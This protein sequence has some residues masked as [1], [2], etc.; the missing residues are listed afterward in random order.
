MCLRLSIAD[1]YWKLVSGSGAS[2][3][4]WGDRGEAVFFSALD[5]PEGAL[6]DIKILQF[7]SDFSYVHRGPKVTDPKQP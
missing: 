6:C 7:L 1:C 2:V 3:R 4:E 5:G